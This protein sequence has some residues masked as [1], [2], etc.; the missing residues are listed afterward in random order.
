MPPENELRALAASR[1]LV[2]IFREL[3]A[4]H[5]SVAACWWAHRRHARDRIEG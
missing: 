1:I 4:A 5:D 2:E 3:G